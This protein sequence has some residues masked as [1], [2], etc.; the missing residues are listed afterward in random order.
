MAE[1]FW[2]EKEIEDTV[3]FQSPKLL[4]DYLYLLKQT[5]EQ[6]NCIQSFVS[7]A[8]K[9]ESAFG[10]ILYWLDSILYDSSSPYYD[11]AFYLQLMN[12]VA[13]SEADSI[14]KLIPL[15]RVEILQKNQVG[16][17]A[18][19]FSFV[20]KEG[21]PHCLYE[22]ETP[23][24]L[25]VF[26]NPDCFLC[27][28]AESNIVKNEKL[29]NMLDCGKL[30]LLAVTPDSDYD[31]WLEHTYPSNWIVGYD[32][33][34]AIYNQRLYDIQRLPCIYLLDKDKR[35]ILKEADYNRL[36]NYLLANSSLFER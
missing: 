4:L 25:V 26:N 35:V 11:E 24:L 7:L 23:L 1:H 17:H 32:K 16:A 13:S 14:M 15:Q 28:Q 12:A 27:H 22:I 10:L 19:N 20:D 2:T 21:A 36:A 34:K 29:Q 8:C 6:Q 9:Q 30:K 31:E 3:N 5:E 18:N 33:E